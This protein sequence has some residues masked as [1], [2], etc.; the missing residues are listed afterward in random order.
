MQGLAFSQCRNFSFPN[1]IV[2]QKLAA[3][4]AY[5]FYRGVVFGSIFLVAFLVY[6]SQLIFGAESLLP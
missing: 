2:L 5:S 4:I 3:D 6:A 1:E